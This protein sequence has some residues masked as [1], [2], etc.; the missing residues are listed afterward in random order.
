MT[1]DQVRQLVRRINPIPDPSTLNTVDVPVPVLERSMDMQVDERPQVEERRYGRWLGPAIGIAAAVVVVIGGLI[2]INDGDDDVATPAPNA[3]ALPDSDRGGHFPP[4]APGAYFADTDGDEET[5]TRGTFVVENS[6]WISVPSGV[7]RNAP[8]DTE[9]AGPYVSLL[10]VEVEQL[11]EDPCEFSPYVA[12]GTSAKAL[13]DQFA[14][15]PRFITREGLAP[16][17]AFGREGYHL[18]LEVPVACSD[19]NIWA[20]GAWGEQLYPEEGQIVEYWFFDVEG[21]TVMVEAT[22]PRDSSREI[23]TELNAE[24]DAVLDTLVLTP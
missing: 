15:M 13:G 8:G 1:H 2:F 14:A 16:V 23:V 19:Q 3:T 24:L 11:S 6:G 12:P 18:V 22:R 9:F 4:V 20:G 7:W 10:V 21:A 17:S 5:T